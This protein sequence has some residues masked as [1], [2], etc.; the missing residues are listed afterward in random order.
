LGIGVL[1]IWR[2][3]VAKGKTK[4]ITDTPTSQVSRIVPGL[5]EVKGTVRCAGPHV[6]SPMTSSPCVLFHFHVEEW[7]QNMNGKGGSWRTVINDIKDSGCILTDGTGDVRINLLQA[8]LLLKPDTHAKS[9]T[10]NDATP[11]LEAALSAYG[12]SSQG[13]IFNKGMRYTETVLREGDRIYAL[14]T[15]SSHPSGGYQM[16]KG[17]NLF[18]V[19]DKTEEEVVA[20]YNK[21]GMLGFIF[22]GLLSV[23][24]L[25]VAALPYLRMI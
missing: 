4:V 2:G 19:S 15:A 7:K 10:F 18:I 3:L 25:G 5:V 11:E 14:G 6:V 9:G 12:R 16:D 22:G 24:G 8:E 1:L 20:H 21:S 13:F 17:N 23:A